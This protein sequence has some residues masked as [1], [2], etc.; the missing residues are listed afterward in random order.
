MHLTEKPGIAVD[1]SG[2]YERKIAALLCHRSQLDEESSKWIREFDQVGGKLAGVELAE[3]F[4]VMR[5]QRP[6]AAKD[7]PAD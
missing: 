1:V 4:R 6:E 7:D 3:V 5:F 2:V